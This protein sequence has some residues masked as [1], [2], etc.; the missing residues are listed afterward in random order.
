MIIIAHTSIPTVSTS[1]TTTI[2]SLHRAQLYPIA[3]S[4]SYPTSLCMFPS[5]LLP[6]HPLTMPCASQMLIHGI[7]DY[8]TVTRKLSLRWPHLMSL[9]VC[10]SIP[11]SPLQN[12]QPAYSANR[13][14]PPYQRHRKVVVQRNLWD[15]F[16]LTFVDQCLFLLALVIF[17]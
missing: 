10:L 12:V 17:I 2:P 9:K 1:P 3:T 4:T 16:M 6:L 13:P 7:A 15:T 11:L 5:P 8:A 14:T